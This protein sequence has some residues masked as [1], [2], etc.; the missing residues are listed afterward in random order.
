MA[1]AL[2]RMANEYDQADLNVEIDLHKIYNLM[3]NQ[4]KP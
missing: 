3:P 1:N 2:V 4:Q